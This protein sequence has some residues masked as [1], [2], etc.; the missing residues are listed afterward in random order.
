MTKNNGLTEEAL[1]SGC[2]RGKL[3]FFVRVRN[4]IGEVA[5]D[6]FLWSI[7][8][9]EQEYIDSIA[10]EDN[11]CA[12]KFPFFLNKDTLYICDNCGKFRR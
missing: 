9:S 2:T 7:Q 11:L 6:I 10:K 1:I 4:W 12:C 8:M 3:P 5:F